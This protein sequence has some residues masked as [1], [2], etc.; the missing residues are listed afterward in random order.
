MSKRDSQE[1]HNKIEFRDQIVWGEGRVEMPVLWGW[2]VCLIFFLGLL[3]CYIY[4]P[5]TFWCFTITAKKFFFSWQKMTVDF[6]RHWPLIFL[7]V[8]KHL[9]K[10]FPNPQNCE[11]ASVVS[12]ALHKIGLSL[13]HCENVELPTIFASDHLIPTIF[14]FFLSQRVPVAMIFFSVPKGRNNG[15]VQLKWLWFQWGGRTAI[16]LIAW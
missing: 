3:A 12:L 5:K 7:S 8:R 6:N 16:L 11:G 13:L 15:E 14:A 1:C 2:C 9:E 10:F 4:L